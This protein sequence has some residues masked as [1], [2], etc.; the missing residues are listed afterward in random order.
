MPVDQ[1]WHFA[2]LDV[3]HEGGLEL[4]LFET[5]AFAFKGWGHP[6]PSRA[7]CRTSSAKTYSTAT[8]AMPTIS[9]SPFSQRATVL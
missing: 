3:L 2:Q 1:A 6:T 5:A 9:R 8:S 7:A 4:V